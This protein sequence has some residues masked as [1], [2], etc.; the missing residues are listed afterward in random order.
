MGVEIAEILNLIIIHWM[1]F[2]L[3]T[4]HGRKNVQK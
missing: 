1:S 2:S 3:Q 4:S